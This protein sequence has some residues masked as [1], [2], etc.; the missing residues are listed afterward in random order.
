MVEHRH[1]PSLLS[2]STSTSPLPF[3]VSAIMSFTQPIQDQFFVLSGRDVGH[4]ILIQTPQFLKQVGPYQDEVED[5]AAKLLACH[6]LAALITEFYQYI[7]A[8]HSSLLPLFVLMETLC[9]IAKGCL[10]GSRIADNHSS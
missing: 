4:R 1:N 8:L 5:T 6:E 9:P 2:T 3:G 7:L 10:H